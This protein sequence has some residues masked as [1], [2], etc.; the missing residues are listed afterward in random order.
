MAGLQTGKGLRGVLIIDDD[1]LATL[2]MIVS[3]Q[4]RSGDTTTFTSSTMAIAFEKE[5]GQWKLRQ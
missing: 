2:N 3:E 5:G 4:S 1:T